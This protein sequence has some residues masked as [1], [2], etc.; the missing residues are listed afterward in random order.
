M[1]WQTELE[2]ILL[3]SAR[4]TAARLASIFAA[5][6]QAAREEERRLCSSHGQPLIPRGSDGANI[7][8]AWSQG[9]FD[10]KLQDGES[11]CSKR[12]LSIQ[13]NKQGSM[14]DSMQEKLLIVPETFGKIDSVAVWGLDPQDILTRAFQIKEGIHDALLLGQVEVDNREAKSKTCNMQTIVHLTQKLWEDRLLVDEA[15]LVDASQEVGRRTAADKKLIGRKTKSL[16]M[17]GGETALQAVKPSRRSSAQP[18]AQ[19]AANRRTSAQQPQRGATAASREGTYSTS[20]SNPAA[21]ESQARQDVVI[22]IV[23]AAALEKIAE[24]SSKVEDAPPRATPRATGSEPRSAPSSPG[25]EHHRI[26]AAKRKAKSNAE[27]GR[28]LDELNADLS[29]SMSGNAIVTAASESTTA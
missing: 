15:A 20:S 5:K 9:F 26:E 14:Q 19:T 12:R 2:A 10:S 23:P 27:L 11:A 1:D 24:S 17:P 29:A 8:Q 13:E 4:T 16:L 28:L 3:D 6:L 22:N 7:Q 21:A 18:R 25:Q